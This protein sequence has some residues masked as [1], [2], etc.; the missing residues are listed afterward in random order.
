MRQPANGPSF[1][2][3][4]RLGPIHW[5]DDCCD[6]PGRIGE[7]L[8]FFRQQGPIQNLT[9][10]VRQPFLKD[11]VATELV[12]PDG[13]G[14]VAPAGPLVQVHVECGITPVATVL[15]VKKNNQLLPGSCHATGSHA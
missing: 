10:P 3:D 11:L 8:H 2:N 14:D 5:L 15:N 13:G 1:K 6:P 12:I 9:L 4:E 7:V